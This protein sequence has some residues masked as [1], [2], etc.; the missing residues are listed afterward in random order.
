MLEIVLKIVK[1]MNEKLM[2]LKKGLEFKRFMEKEFMEIRK[3]VRLRKI[4]KSAEQ[5]I[6]MVQV[7][8]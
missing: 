1:I 2:L 5:Q 3:N 6:H 7:K 8:L 4:Q